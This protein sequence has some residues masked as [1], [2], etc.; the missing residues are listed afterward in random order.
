M[1]GI[2]G[3]L[4]A[5][6]RLLAT[7]IVALMRCERPRVVREQGLT[8]ESWLRAV[9]R[10]TGAD[11]G[12]L[13]IAAER[14]AD[15][16]ATLRLF[17]DGVL[18]WGTV[19]GIVCAVKVL[20][21]EQRRWLD[22]T[23]AGDDARLRSL[24]GDAVIADAGHLV[25]RARPD[26]QRERARR[27]AAGQR[28]VLQPGMDGTGMAIAA[29][30]AETF[31]AVQTA[32]ETITHD[33][34]GRR[35]TTNIEALRALA[36]QR[37]TRVGR[38]TPARRSAQAEVSSTPDALSAQVSDPSTLVADDEHEARDADIGGAPSTARPEM[39]VVTDVSLLLDPVLDIDRRGVERATDAA[40]TSRDVVRLLWRQDRP[41]PSLTPEAVRRLACDATVRPVLTDGA[42]VLGTA[43]P[44]AKV[45]ASLRAALIARDGGCRFAACHRPVEVCEAHHI[46]PRFRGGPTVLD[47]LA[48]LCAAH[49][50]AVHEGG[51]R[52]T[53]HDDESM[54]F[55]RRGI[56]L[57]S[58]PR[59]AQVTVPVRPPPVGRRR[60]PERRQH[61]AAADDRNDAPAPAQPVDLPF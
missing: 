10:R 33:A 16:P 30:D 41:A 59:A 6:D 60:H 9:A 58:V 19:R 52:A 31:T 43:E 23:L 11:A 32:I 20:T 4:G 50:H 28:L 34:A 56:T 24:D 35:V 55:V 48:L 54:V 36:R 7:V 38:G 51:W 39:I 49:H 61:A 27:A 47:N 8:T 5:I 37:L 42:K 1:E 22:G 3:L 29:M 2:A 21:S 40:T 26:L 44:Y 12:M 18:S 13:M 57:R 25:D 17:R 53:L 45:S 14:L 15:M 46:V